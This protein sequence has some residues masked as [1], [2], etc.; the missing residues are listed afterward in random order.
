MLEIL[1]QFTLLFAP[2]ALICAV[3]LKYT[4]PTQTSQLLRWLG[5]RLLATADG[6]DEYRK[7]RARGLE[8]WQRKAAGSS[9]APS[10]VVKLKPT[11]PISA[12]RTA[13][14]GS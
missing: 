7:G 8:R 4:I 6:V 9:S 2:C 10:A 5:V 12:A 14:F 3:A 13:G 1:G 11:Q